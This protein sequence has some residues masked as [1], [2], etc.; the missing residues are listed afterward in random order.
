MD[1]R[2][3]ALTEWPTAPRPRPPEEQRKIFCPRGSP[4]HIEKAQNRQGNQRKSKPFSLI[5]FARIW[6]GL[7]WIWVNL[8]LA[9]KA[10]RRRSQDQ[11]FNQRRLNI[12]IATLFP[13][14]L[15]DQLLDAGLDP[16]GAQ[17]LGGDDR[18]HRR[19]TGRPSPIFV[20]RGWGSWA[21]V[22]PR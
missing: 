2:W 13:H 17:P 7:G 22:Q 18:R 10:P 14:E 4:Q 1:C 20:W 5:S 8:A 6:A 12:D 21:S 16:S 15:L 3:Q 19:A 9:W 11:L